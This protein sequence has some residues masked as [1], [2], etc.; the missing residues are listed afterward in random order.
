VNPREQLYVLCWGAAAVV[1]AFCGARALAAQAA[2]RGDRLPRGRVAALFAC[3]IGVGL[4]GAKL[5]FV[6][7]AVSNAVVVDRVTT[8]SAL[9]RAPLVSGLRITGGLLAAGAT[10]ALAGPAL[11]GRRLEALAILDALAPPVGIA[12]AVGRLGCLAAG[13]CFGTPSELPWAITY[14]PTSRPYWNH[15]A[16]G[17]LAEGAQHSLRVHPL[18]IY[19]VAAGLL[20]TGTAR[21]LGQSSQ[22]DGAVTLWFTLVTAGARLAIEP[23]RETRLLETIVAQQWLSLGLVVAATVALVLRASGRTRQSA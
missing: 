15:V 22:R 19:F 12:T 1:W 21:L 23:F 8:A 2:K 7:G 17:L 16:R 5:H 4:V 14:G 13:C 6:A 3:T 20:A 10:L 11:L 18:P 9:V